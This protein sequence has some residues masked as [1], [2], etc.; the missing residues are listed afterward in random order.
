MDHVFLI[1]SPVDGQLIWLPFFVIH[2]LW[3]PTKCQQKPW[4][5]KAKANIV[6]NFKDPSGV[7]E[8]L[9]KILI[10]DGY[11]YAF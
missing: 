5:L 7:D 4:M 3:E 9:Q 6:S 10:I 2:S 8:E 11:D 1:L